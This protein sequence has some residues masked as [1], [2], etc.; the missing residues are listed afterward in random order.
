MKLLWVLTANFC[1]TRVTNERLFFPVISID[2]A[3]RYLLSF[4]VG[5]G[6]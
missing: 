4:L 6:K 2:Q 3:D 5:A 1:P